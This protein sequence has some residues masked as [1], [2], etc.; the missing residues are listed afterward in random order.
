MA[1][2][3]S[4]DMAIV[5]TGTPNPVTEGTLL[6][7]TLTVTNNGPASATNVTVTDTLPSA[8]TYLST[9]T[10]QGSCS[11]A[12]GT[13]TC[14][15]GTMANAATATISILTIPGGV[16]HCHEY[17]DRHGR[18]D[19]S[20]PGEQY[21]DAER[22]DYGADQDHA[23][24]VLGASGTDKNGA[25]RVVLTWKTGGEAHNLGFNVYREQNGN[26]VR[27]NPSLI[28][29]SAL[30]MSGALPK[31]AGRSYAWIDLR[32]RGRSILLAGRYGRE[33]HAHHARAGFGV[34]DSGI[35][36]ASGMQAESDVTASETRMLSQMNQAQPPTPGSQE[37]HLVETL[38]AASAPTRGQIQKQFELAAHPAVKIYVRHEGWYRVAQPDLVKA[39]L[40]PNVDP[41]LLHLYAEATEQP[42]QITGATAGPGGFGPQAAINFYGTGI[43]TVFSGTRVYWLVAGRRPRA[44]GFRSL[45][46]SSGSNQPPASYSATVELQ[47]HTI[48]F[49]ALLTSNGRELLRRV[50]SRPLR[51]S[52][53]YEVPH[54]DAIFDADGAT[55]SV[56]QGVITAFPHDVTVALNGTPL[57][58]VDFTGQD[59]G[60]FERQHSDRSA[61][62]R[63]ATRSRLTAQNGE[64]DTSLVDYIRITYPHTVRGGFR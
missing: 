37:S 6:T 46:V 22:D 34:G 31:H 23:A 8:V 48:Y 24:V 47:Q 53:C 38:P 5:K 2:A 26:R 17:R 52:R 32:G 10:T 60:D 49:A 15:L 39:G 28:A 35:G 27:M 64:Y 30:L 44:R 25:N 42:M 9:S 4:A 57:G 59:T 61:A 58:D 12:G 1:R 63:G 45:P 55:G 41:A 62:S 21:I 36:A 20:E 14:L 11:E 56:L 43:D 29:G 54:L 33:R 19:G 3:N 18:P 51:W 50:W 13:V 16:G 7:Y 40:D